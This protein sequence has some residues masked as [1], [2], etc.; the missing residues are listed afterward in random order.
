MT[1]EGRTPLHASF[2][3]IYLRNSPEWYRLD[4]DLHFPRVVVRLGLWVVHLYVPTVI[5]VIWHPTSEKLR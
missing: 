5:T 1:S 3:G 2:P 4:L